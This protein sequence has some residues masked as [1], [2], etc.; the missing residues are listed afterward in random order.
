MNQN[1]YLTV[2]GALFAI[3]AV[4]HALRLVLGWGVHIGTV[5]VPMWIS[6][7]GL[8]IAGYLA[9]TACGLQRRRSA[10]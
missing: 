8:L 3:I 2:T 7:A 9:V 5:E 10:G 1:A 6:W 4:L